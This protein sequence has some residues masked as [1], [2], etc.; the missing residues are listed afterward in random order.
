[1]YAVRFCWSRC[2]ATAP[3]VAWEGV[4]GKGVDDGHVCDGVALGQDKEDVPRSLDKYSRAVSG[5]A[6][7]LSEAGELAECRLEGRGNARPVHS[8]AQNPFQDIMAQR[9]Q[10]CQGGA[11]HALFSIHATQGGP[12][13]A[14]NGGGIQGQHG[15][16]EVVPEA[17][18]DLPALKLKRVSTARQWTACLPSWDCPK[19][20]GDYWQRRSPSAMAAWACPT[21]ALPKVA[22]HTSLPPPPPH[23]SPCAALSKPLGSLI[24]PAAKRSA[25]SGRLCTT[26]QVPCGSRNFVSLAPTA[27]APSLMPCLPHLI[28]AQR[29]ADM[30]ALASAV[31]LRGIPSYPQGRAGCAHGRSHGIVAIEYLALLLVCCPRI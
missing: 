4:L 23:T 12:A 5:D 28:P 16:A 11:T 13:S 14:L 6:S 17:C 2:A 7:A 8:K 19:R 25:P 20:R 18:L 24:D 1:M 26:A 22:P 29:Q 3:A 10:C 21:L 9:G 15:E 30:P 31:V 27:W